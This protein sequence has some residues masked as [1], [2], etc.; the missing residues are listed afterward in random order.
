MIPSKSPRRCMTA[1]WAMSM[2]AISQLATANEAAWQALKSGGQVV[3]MR[4]TTVDQGPGKGNP[5]LRDPTCAK[6]RN[7]SSQGKEEAVRVGTTF[8]TRA[9][10]VGEVMSSPY[11]RTRDTARHAFGQTTP[12]EFLFL[13]EVLTPAEVARNTT[14]AMQ[15]IGEY[16]GTVNL[17]MVTHE[18]NI[19]AITFELVEQGAFL[20]LKPRGG[21]KFD[22]VGKIRLEDL[23]D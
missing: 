16:G 8:K 7:L 22:V 14:E 19:A 9:I 18:P 21:S 10:P 13:S 17:V 12:T 1:A 4:H 2:F 3:L 23:A 5:L 15:R 20:V 11:C 6:E